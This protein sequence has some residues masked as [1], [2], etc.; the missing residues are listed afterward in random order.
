MFIGLKNEVTGRRS[1]KR[2]RNL[3]AQLVGG[4]IDRE[5]KHPLR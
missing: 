3:Q 4:P 5:V 2:G 1:A